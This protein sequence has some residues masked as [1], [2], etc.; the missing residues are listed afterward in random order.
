[1]HPRAVGGTWPQQTLQKP[2]FVLTHPPRLTRTRIRGPHACLHPPSHAC[3]PLPL[4]PPPHPTPRHP[5][6]QIILWELLTWEVPW[7]EYGPWQVVALITEGKRP[8]VHGLL[9]WL[10][11]R[12]EGWAPVGAVSRRHGCASLCYT[13]LCCRAEPRTL[14]LSV[15]CVHALSSSR[16]YVVHR[17]TL[18]VVCSMDPQT[19]WSAAESSAC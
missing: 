7:A 9:G 19:P 12:K 6:L 11:K 14:R 1:M 15:P 18:L 3:T 10:C 4:P 17:G 13:M 8:Q 16:T 2:T 5:C